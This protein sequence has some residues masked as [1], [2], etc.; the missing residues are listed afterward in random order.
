MAHA[1]AKPHGES[2]AE[3]LFIELV[4]FSLGTVVDRL[5]RAAEQGC[6]GR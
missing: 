5:G 3:L 6:V 2:L 1:T 4:D